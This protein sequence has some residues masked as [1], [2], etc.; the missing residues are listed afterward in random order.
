MPGSDSI[1]FFRTLFT[2]GGKMKIHCIQTGPLSVNTYIV[3]LEQGGCFIVDPAA[4]RFCHD[5]GKFIAFLES[6]QLEPKAIVLTHGHFDHVSG[7][8]VL[9]EKYPKIEI[10]IHRDDAR[11]IGAMSGE[12]QSPGLEMMGFEAFVPAVSDLP[13]ATDFL[14]DG[15]ILFGNWQVIHTPGHTKGCCCLYSEKEK[16]LI[17]GDTLF[18]GTWGRT[19]LP[20]GSETQIMHSLAVLKEKIPGETL[21]Y[22]GHD[23]NGFRMDQAF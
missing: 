4:C 8:K 20:G 9:K 16:T 3:P 14:A 23:Y 17:S 7:L 12:L 18:Y 15:K 10:Y 11:M 2:Y 13:E 19:D 6:L 21:V 1:H 5:E 22:P